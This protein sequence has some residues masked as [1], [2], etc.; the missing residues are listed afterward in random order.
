MRNAHI[1]FV[2]LLTALAP[3]VVA[4]AELR[5]ANVFTD[6]AVLQQGV[7]LPMWGT[8]AANK[9]VTVHFAGQTKTTQAAA[10]GS[11]RIELAPLKA[12][13]TSDRMIV[14][15]G[16]QRIEYRALLVGEVW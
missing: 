12:N 7:D 14:A 1:P 2:I 11:W 4:A 5:I 13:A 3:V 15:S 10:D 16:D 6:H 8:T 9:P